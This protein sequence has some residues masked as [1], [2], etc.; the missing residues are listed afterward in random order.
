MTRPARRSCWRL[1]YFGWAR[2]VPGV[3]SA[4]GLTF[5]CGCWP[6]GAAAG[7]GFADLE[8]GDRAHG[9]AGGFADQHAVLVVDAERVIG[10]FYGEGA[11]G[12]GDADVDA[13]PGNAQ[14]AA[15]ADAP[16]DADRL[17][18]GGSVDRRAGASPR[19]DPPRCSGPT[20]R[21]STARLTVIV[22]A[23][24]SGE[25]LR[26][27]NTTAPELRPGDNGRGGGPRCC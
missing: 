27:G 10:A 12:V 4:V 1:G 20:Q 7:F 24:P 8:S 15:A 19:S 26:H 22:G 23:G 17:G 25:D 13:L 9:C 5:R 14:R 16:L 6:S 21:S 18:C 2:G 3:D 11:A